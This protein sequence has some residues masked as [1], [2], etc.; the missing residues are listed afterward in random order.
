[1]LS[2]GYLLLKKRVSSYVRP[3]MPPVAFIIAASFYTP[4]A[5]WWS[6]YL[7]PLLLAFTVNHLSEAAVFVRRVLTL[8]PLRFLGLWSYSLYLWQEPFYEFQKYFY[9]PVLAFLAAMIVGVG[10]FYLFE[11]PIRDWLNR[12]YSKEAASAAS[13]YAA[14]HG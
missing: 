10:S 1:M 7:T 5:P 12:K 2:A 11:R 13:S 4:Y 3:W 14:A 9:T 6:I 8:T